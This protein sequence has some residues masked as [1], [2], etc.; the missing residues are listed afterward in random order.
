MIEEIRAKITG[1]FFFLLSL[2]LLL[3][4]IS[5]TPYDLGWYTSDPYF[6]PHNW[7]QQ[8]GAYSAGILVLTLG[9]ASVLVPVAV[10]IWGI[11]LWNAWEMRHRFF[12]LAGIF[13]LLFSFPTL[14]S[15]TLGNLITTQMTAVGGILG[16]VFGDFLLH[17]FGVI[18]AILIAFTV[19]LLA[20]LV[21]TDF[22][23]IPFV[24]GLAKA[25]VLATLWLLDQWA[26]LAKGKKQ[27][28]RIVTNAKSKD[29]TAIKRV[30]QKQSK[31]QT[32]V[33]EFLE[34]NPEVVEPVI[35]Q[36]A[37]AD[38][39]RAKSRYELPH[40]SLMEDPPA[41]DEPNLQE[42]LKNQS[43]ILEATL[44]DF[45]ID[46]RV[47]EVN[48]GPVITRYEVQPAPGVKVQKIMTLSDDIALAM[49][50]SSVRIILIPGTSRLGVEVP[51]RAPALVYLKEVLAS[52]EYQSQRKDKRLLLALGKDTSGVAI[53]A[54][55]AEMPHLLI[56]GTTGS[57]KTVCVNTLLLS[58]LFN[59]TPDQ[60][61]LLMVDPKMV[62]LVGFNEVPHLI[63]PV[64][65]EYKK[66]SIA[67]NWVVEEMERRYRLLAGLGARNIS[68]YN[69]KIRQEPKSQN[70]EE[71]EEL[72]PLSYLI[73]II[74][75]LADLMMILANEIE[76]A[77]TRLA[78][79][80]RA[81]G[82][83]MILATQRPSVDVIT[84]VI[85]ANFPARISFKVASKVDSRTVL[86]MNGAEKLL[87]KGDMLF[88]KPGTLRPIRAQS[89]LVS[90][91]EIERLVSFL[92]KQWKPEYNEILIEAQ[93]IKEEGKDLGRDEFFEEAVRIVLDTG[94][95][96]ASILQRRLRV[97][98]TRAARLI[99]MMEQRGIVG[100]FKGSKARDL[101]MTREEFENRVQQKP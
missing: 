73:V 72:E 13:T 57:G 43:E 58:L 7:I 19:T 66:V 65:T 60:L 35:R 21:T 44:Q 85:K 99:D 51:N 96:S 5:Y 30:G 91:A 42:D 69:Q 87:G 15:V 77:I 79:L 89:A 22:L 14:L 25:L 97:G 12:K 95:A 27:T 48:Q 18:G 64:V 81:V 94:Q 1:G 67:L 75:E 17:Y 78:Q 45:S 3:S 36:H 71:A 31:I 52:E 33:E 62:E 38:G 70:G 41:V 37:P 16:M 54:D 20:I 39:E 23:A 80:S 29:E 76:G 63:C 40:L 50:A 82:I 101:L 84:G 47:E 88:L 56:A 55:L 74:D 24:V 68:L 28:R 61:K 92:K 11:G 9:W 98:Y 93:Q 59:N 100:P 83:H 32:K 86:D 4:L 53:V 34:E 2:L 26:L 8:V 90:D 10:L 46:A 6:P 49:K